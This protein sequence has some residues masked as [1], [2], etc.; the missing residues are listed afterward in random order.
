MGDN[1]L[2]HFMKGRPLPAFLNNV[3]NNSIIENNVTLEGPLSLKRF[4]NLESLDISGHKITK[5][6][7]S[8]CPHIRE[9]HCSRN[10]LTNIDI[11]NNRQI[12][13]I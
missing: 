4:V 13:T 2:S 1:L 3:I 12:E 6:D 9:L 7:V 8:D 5:L 10:Q 11:S